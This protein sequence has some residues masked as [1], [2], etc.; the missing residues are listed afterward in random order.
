MVRGLAFVN[1]PTAHSLLDNL[2][3]LDALITALTEL[4]KVCEAVEDGYLDSLREGKFERWDER[5]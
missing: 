3:S 1:I 2:S 4:D 5:R